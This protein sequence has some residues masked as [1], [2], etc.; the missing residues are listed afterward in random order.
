V[1]DGSLAGASV[2]RVNAG[3]NRI[4]SQNAVAIPDRAF[5]DTG[6]RDNAIA[7]ARV[8]IAQAQSSRVAGDWVGIFRTV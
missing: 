4:G 6:T 5:A 8:G 3:V 2:V 7:F 1:T